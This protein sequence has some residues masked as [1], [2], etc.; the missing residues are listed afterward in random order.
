MTNVDANGVDDA[1]LQIMGLK[2]RV[3]QSEVGRS[4]ERQREERREERDI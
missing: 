4:R 2:V 3:R 1:A